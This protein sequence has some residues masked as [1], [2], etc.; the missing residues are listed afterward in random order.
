MNDKGTYFGLEI[1]DGKLVREADIMRL[2]FA[3]F[4]RE[5]SVG[6]TTLGHPDSNNHFVYLHD[7]ERFAELFIR[8]GRHRFMRPESPQKAATV[9]QNV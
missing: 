3:E 4:W 2:P 1:I 5:S 8:T 6:S 7:W 9:D